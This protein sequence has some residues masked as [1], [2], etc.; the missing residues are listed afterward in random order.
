MRAVEASEHRAEDGR[1]GRA[2][3]RPRSCSNAAA[4]RRGRI[5][6]S[7]GTR[8]ANGAN[9]TTSAALRDEADARSELLA[10]DV[11]E[12]AA[13]AV[14]VVGARLVDLVGH[15]ERD[16]RRGDELRVR[17]LEARARRPRR[18]S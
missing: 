4:C 14:V 6:V 17:V 1:R 2:A 12:E 5:H 8:A 18:G 9:A 3:R 15:D 11:A 13:L 10:E 7:K 16:D